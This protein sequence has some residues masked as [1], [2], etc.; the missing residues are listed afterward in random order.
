MKD[1]QTFHGSPDSSLWIIGN[2][3]LFSKSCFQKARV[4]YINQWTLW[5]S[6]TCMTIGPHFMLLY[7]YINTQH[8]FSA[9]LIPNIYNHLQY[10][11]NS[12]PVGTFHMKF[13]RQAGS[14]S[15]PITITTDNRYSCSTHPAFLIFLK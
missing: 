8:N 5:F 9:F 13:R 11:I 2:D 7:T 4:L 3:I 10:D 6:F 1:A 12:Q 14:K 15:L